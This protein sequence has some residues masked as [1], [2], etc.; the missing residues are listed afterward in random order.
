MTRSC[1]V[2]TD[3]NIGAC[4][5]LLPLPF[6]FLTSKVVQYPSTHYYSSNSSLVLH[7]LLISQRCPNLIML[8]SKRGKV[9]SADQS[10]VARQMRIVASSTR[11]AAGRTRMVSS[12]HVHP[13]FC[14]VKTVAKT[15]TCHSQ[16]QE[17]T[18]SDILHAIPYP[19]RRQ[20]CGGRCQG[21]AAGALDRTTSQLGHRQKQSSSAV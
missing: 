21:S 3:G 17:G 9:T 4:P 18:I 16:Q 6:S 7:S 5:F 12:S 14:V 1:N 20:F 10:R 19:G 8:L 2:S 11:G 15:T 13:C